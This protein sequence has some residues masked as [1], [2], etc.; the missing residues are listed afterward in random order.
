MPTSV[1]E[2]NGLTT[3]RAGSNAASTVLYRIRGATPSPQYTAIGYSGDVTWSD[4]GAGGSFVLSGTNDSVAD[5]TP[6]NKTQAV[7]ITATSGAG[8]INKALTVYGT[9]PIQPNTGA[10]FE[11][12]VET[13]IKKARDGTQYAR[14][15]Y[16]EQCGWVFG[17]ERR[18]WLDRSELMNFWRDHKKSVQFYLVDTE[19]NLMNKVWFVSSFKAVFY[20]ANVWAMSAAFKGKFENV[21]AP[22]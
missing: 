15:D 22:E 3:Y 20:G 5:Y 14:E 7:T 8:S 12:D 18:E 17:W 19:G 21:G 13:K 10:E 16:G 2:T 1:V 9:M 4:N 6:R 11:L